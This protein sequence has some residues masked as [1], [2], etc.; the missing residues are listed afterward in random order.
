MKNVQ[1]PWVSLGLLILRVGTAALLIYAHGWGKLVNFG[2]RAGRFADPIGLGSE[3]SLALVVFA[4]VICAALIAVGLWTRFAAIPIVIFGLIAAFVH[5][6]D[7]PF[8]KKELAL[9]YAIPALTLVLTGAGLFSLDGAFFGKG[10]K[11]D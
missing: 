7:D 11:S 2:E 9:L 1:D 10:K 5:H 6:I 8:A 4:E 3:L